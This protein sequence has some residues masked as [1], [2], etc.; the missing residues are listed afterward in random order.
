M[1]CFA[2]HAFPEK[3]HVISMPVNAVCVCARV[4][5]L[6][7]FSFSPNIQD[8]SCYNCGALINMPMAQVNPCTNKQNH[9]FSLRSSPDSFQQTSYLLVWLKQWG[10]FRLGTWTVQPWPA[11]LMRSNRYTQFPKKLCPRHLSAAT[12]HPGGITTC[13]RK[14]CFLCFSKLSEQLGPQHAEIFFFLP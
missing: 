13:C 10:V 2:L 6:L 9:L 11:V 8:L 4:F 7:T 12:V 1:N 3:I 14:P 5:L